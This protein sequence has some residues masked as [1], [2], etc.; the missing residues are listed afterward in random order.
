MGPNGRSRVRTTTYSD[1][2][3]IS[4]SVRYRVAREILICESA[5]VTLNKNIQP[6]SHPFHFRR[7]IKTV[8]LLFRKVSHPL[9]ASVFILKE[10]CCS[11]PWGVLCHRCAS[12]HPC[13]TIFMYVVGPSLR[14]AI[15]SLCL[16]QRFKCYPNQVTLTVMECL[17]RTTL[18]RGVI[19]RCIGVN[20]ILH[21]LFVF[22]KVII[23]TRAASNLVSH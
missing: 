14:S 1:E 9:A 12:G 21:G 7:I 4:R 23:I 13:N 16:D 11:H 8:L 10:D 20:K 22:R 17:T 6:Q 15:R 19:Y 3:W 2:L 5:L 18:C